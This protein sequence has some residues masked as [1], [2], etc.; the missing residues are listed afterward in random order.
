MDNSNERPVP[1]TSE[2]LHVDLR[3][4]E[5][6]KGLSE[7]TLTAITNTA[8]W[9]KFHAGE[10]VIEVE[11]EIT[12][13]YFLITGR[14]QS[15]LY[16]WL[17]KEIQKDT[18]VRGFA[19]G[20]I[21]LGSS[22]RSLPARRGYR[23]FDSNTI[24]AIG[25]ASADREACRLSTCSVSPGNER[26]QTIRDGRSLPSE[27]IRRGYCSSHRGEPSTRRSIGASTSR[28]GRVTVYC[29]RRRAMETGRRYPLQIVCWRSARSERTFLKTGPRTGDFW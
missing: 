9:V 8:E 7:E 28:L 20:L 17:G 24:D 16:D 15:T 3:R 26:L 1:P 13:V 19:I 14:V 21:A 29:R 2:Q 4:L 22:D 25:P 6:A 10:V 11:S 18:I 12:H 5:W 23:A 27:A